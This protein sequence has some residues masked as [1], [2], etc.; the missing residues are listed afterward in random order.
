MDIGDFFKKSWTRNFNNFPQGSS[1]P[2]AETIPI[3][4]ASWREKKF[5]SKEIMYRVDLP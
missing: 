4:G 5:L 3:S 2:T 1:G